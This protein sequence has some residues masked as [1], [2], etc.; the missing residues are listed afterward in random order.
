MRKS[1]Y[2][3]IVSLYSRYLRNCRTGSNFCRISL[4]NS[5][6]FCVNL[7]ILHTLVAEVLGDKVSLAFNFYVNGKWGA[8]EPISNTFLHE[9]L[10]LVLFSKNQKFKK[11]IFYDKKNDRLL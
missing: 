7:F 4:G 11:M 10:V 5:N 6:F 8:L 1:F 3:H 9:K 2:K